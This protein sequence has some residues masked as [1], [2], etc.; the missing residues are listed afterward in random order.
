VAGGRDQFKKPDPAAGLLKP[1]RERRNLDMNGSMGAEKGTAPE[2]EKE[3]DVEERGFFH[4][5]L[6][7]HKAV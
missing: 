7:R 2:T 6:N 1:L 3:K 4:S 5:P